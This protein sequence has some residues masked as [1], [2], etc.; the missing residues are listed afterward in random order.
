MSH[1]MLKRETDVR[2][3][4]HF[5][6]GFEERP[7]GTPPCWGSAKKTHALQWS[8]NLPWPRQLMGHTSMSPHQA[9][10]R[11]AF[12]DMRLGPPDAKGSSAIPTGDTVDGCEIHFAP[13]FGNPAWFLPW[14]HFVVRTGFCNHL[15][16]A[17]LVVGHPTQ[18]QRIPAV[19][20]SRT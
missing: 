12:W 1:S 15:Q 2:L 11:Q 18:A 20:W 5:F 13:P 14:F 7:K 8:C 10:A 16:Y 17:C 19:R 6:G 9:G 4:R 3:A